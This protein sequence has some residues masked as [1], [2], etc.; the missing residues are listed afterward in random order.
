MNTARRAA[1]AAALGTLAIFAVAACGGSTPEPKDAPS[2]AAQ[3]KPPETPKTDEKGNAASDSSEDK[4]AKETDEDKKPAGD[5]AE[6]TFPEGASVDQAMAAVPKG[7]ARANID[8]E[9]LA[10]PLQ[11]PGVFD[12]CKVGSQHFKVRVAVW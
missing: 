12:S 3:S 2:G 1:V 8:P 10:E 6:P 4:A 11:A 9:R 5:S 7:T